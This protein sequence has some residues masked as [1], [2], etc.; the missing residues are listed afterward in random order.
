MATIG[1]SSAVR[2]KDRQLAQHQAALTVLQRFLSAP[3]RTQFSWLDLACGRGQIL[4]GLRDHL[5]DKARAKINFV[6]YDVKQD[7]LLETQKL[8]ATLNLASVSAHVGDISDFDVV[9]SEHER[10]DFISFTNTVHEVAPPRLADVLVNATRRL[11]DNGTLFIYDMERIKPPELGALPFSAAD[12]KVVVT[13]LVESLSGEDYQPEVSQWQHR[14]VKGWNVQIQREYI[15][16]TGKE[17]EERR[18]QAV[19][20]TRDAIASVLRRRIDECQSALEALTLFGSE[21]VEEE[22]DREHLLFELWAI[23]RALGE[24]Q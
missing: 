17:L 2:I 14:T 9:V 19:E 3:D 5:S 10:F 15:S 23:T 7:Y 1:D 24:S 13:A 6:A 20:H 8:A 21:T 16:A 4:G 22:E 18:C 12:F 11:N